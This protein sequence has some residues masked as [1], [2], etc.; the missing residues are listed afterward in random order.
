MF[1]LD[2]HHELAARLELVAKGAVNH[3]Y[4]DECA[5][6]APIEP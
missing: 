2:M 4:Q 1:E 5:V 6:Q 3:M